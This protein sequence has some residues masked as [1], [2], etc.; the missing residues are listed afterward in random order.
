MLSGPLCV[1]PAI[2]HFFELDSLVSAAAAT[3]P[4][5]SRGPG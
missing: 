3:G 5:G 2:Q 4:I 1:S